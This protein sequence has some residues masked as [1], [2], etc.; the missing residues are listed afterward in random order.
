MKNELKITAIRQLKALSYFLLDLVLYITIIIIIRLD[1]FFILIVIL[2]LSLLTIFPVIFLHFEYIYRNRNEEYE[3]SVDKIIK[4]KENIESVYN[5]DD[6]KKVEIY[7]SPNYYNN[8]LYFTAFANYHFA[9][10]YLISGEILYITSL[11]APGGIDKAFSL[12]LKEIP[13]RR[14]K[15]IFATTLY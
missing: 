7:V 11:L 4:R 9:K 10:V 15:R 14:I 5:K 1:I 6:I 13:F 2:P 8:E 12:Y 3:L